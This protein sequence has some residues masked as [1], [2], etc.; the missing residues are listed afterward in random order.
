MPSYADL[1]AQ[2]EP[3]RRRIEALD[4]PRTAVGVDTSSVAAGARETLAAIRE[5]VS[6]RGL[7]A[8]VAPV[9]GNAPS[10]ATPVAEVAKPDGGRVLYQRVRAEDAAEFVEAALVRGEVDNRWLLGALAGA[11]GVKRMDHHGWGPIQ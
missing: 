8:D 2:A 4:R 1:L 5:A 7:D 3:A 11:E 9:G 10:F 6:Q